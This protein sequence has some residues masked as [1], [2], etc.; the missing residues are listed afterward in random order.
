MHVRSQSFVVRV[1]TAMLADTRAA[2]R[3]PASL[4]G[5]LLAAPERSVPSHSPHGSQS[6]AGNVRVLGRALLVTGTRDTHSGDEWHR[7]QAAGTRLWRSVHATVS[8]RPWY[9]FQP[10]HGSQSRAGNVR[11]LGCALLVTGARDTHS[12]DEW[13]PSQAVGT[14]LGRAVHATVSLRPWYLFWPRHGS[15]SR[16][17]NVRVLERALLVTG[18]RDT[19]SGDEWHRSQAVG[20]RLG[21]SVHAAVSLR[22]WYLFWP[23]RSGKR[24]PFGSARC[25]SR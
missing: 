2:V 18:T 1:C 17:G 20:T 13:H 5:P 12:G 7:S 25:L 15:Q 3:R 19:H 22:P 24:G 16:V 10:R 11:V 9:L 14:R 4:D 21:R 8:L 6:R 23:R